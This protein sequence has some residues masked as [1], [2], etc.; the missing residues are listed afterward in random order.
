MSALTGQLTFTL[1]QAAE[2]LN[3]HRET[4]RRAILSGELRAAKLGNGFRISR[5]DLEAFWISSGGGELFGGIALDSLQAGSTR[6]DKAPAAAKKKGA[7][8]S[9]TRQ[10]QF[11]L[12]HSSAADK[13][14]SRQ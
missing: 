6:P 9:R 2:L 8:P 5:C 12:L 4:L 7:K 13:G 3:C 14:K 1:A 11:S 10:E